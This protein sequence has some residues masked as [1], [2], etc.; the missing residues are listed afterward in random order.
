[1]GVYIQ[2]HNSDKEGLFL[3]DARGGLGIHT[4]AKHVQKAIGGRVFLIFGVGN[5]RRFYLW[6]SFTVQDVE[7][8]VDGEGK[9]AFQATGPGYFL[10]P[11]VRLDGPEFDDFKS[12]CANFVGFRRVDDL[13][14]SKTLVKLANRQ[15]AGSTTDVK[16]FVDGLC[17]LL[18][19]TDQAKLVRYFNKADGKKLTADSQTSM[20]A[21]SIRQPH[22]E[23]I[24]R[25]TKK[26]EYR[27]G[28]TNIRGRILIYAA[29]GRYSV[30]EEARMMKM[31]RMNELNIDAL[32][33]GVIIGSV[34]LFDCDGGNWHV[35]KPERAE[36][37]AVP[38]SH[39]QPVWFYPFRVT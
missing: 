1:L 38:K 37:L 9:P 24:L 4:R 28:P 13:P 31:Y 29:K 33:R 16:H 19:P 27:S 7:P 25:G 26:I 23:A 20:R 11:P 36:K 10:Q 3:C 30:D 15:L 2:Y 34:E 32:P 14:Y 39:P 21:L 8:I 18:R 35:R 6:N 22:A 12:E 5:P 17:R